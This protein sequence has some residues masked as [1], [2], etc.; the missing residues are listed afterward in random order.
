MAAEQGFEDIRHWR[1]R[2][3]NNG[4]GKR[5]CLEAFRIQVG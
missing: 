2:I 4:K 5:G 1:L 3:K